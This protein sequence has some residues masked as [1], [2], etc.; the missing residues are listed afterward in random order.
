MTMEALPPGIDAA[1]LTAVLRRSGLPPAGRVRDVA[2][3][4]SFPTLLSHIFRLRLGYD[5]PAGGCPETLILKAGLPGRPGGPWKAGR[6]EVA[7]YG[8]V[9]PAT[10]AGLLPRCFDAAWEEG[11]GAWHLLLED[12]T[13]THRIATP[14]PLPP[15]FADA[16]AI[17]RARARFHAAWWDHPRLGADVG[18]WT[19]AAGQDAWRQDMAEKYARFAAELG[20]GL[21]PGRSALYA[22]LFEAAPR[23]GARY[24]SHRH[25]TIIQGDAHIWNCFLPVAEGQGGARLFD[26]DAWSPNV[27]TTDLAYMMAIHWYPELRRRFEEPLL[28][29]Y[30]AELLAQGIAGYDRAALQEDYRL[31][32]LWQVATPLWQH[33]LGI[34][35][36]I[37]WNN[38]ERVHM[39]AEDLDCRALLG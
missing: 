19:D 16:E 7:F 39:A 21:P 26:W 14:W 20:D 32:V 23:L 27:G 8:T 10:P 29:A 28:D 37:W 22:R 15:S 34:P 35:P 24:R 3:E 36:L 12:L 17:I 2:A 25:M 31:S 4:K 6:H 18:A 1:F 13:D 11:T 30:H 33:A 9:A 38:L 5:G